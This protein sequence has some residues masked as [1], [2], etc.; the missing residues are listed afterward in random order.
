[1]LIVSPLLSASNK[2]TRMPIS[3]DILDPKAIAAR[4]LRHLAHAQARGRLVRLDQLACDVGVRRGDVRQ[5]V[6]RLDAEGHVDAQRMRLT[7]SGL[8]L[9]ASMRGQQLREPRKRVQ[10]VQQVA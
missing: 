10:A 2:E 5:M 8:A 9:A 1:M 7:L 4:V 6:S 3:H